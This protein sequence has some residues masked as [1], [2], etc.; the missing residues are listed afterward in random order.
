MT[1]LIGPRP[2]Q[3]PT[4]GGKS[5]RLGGCRAGSKSGREPNSAG[6]TG[7]HL[8]GAGWTACVRASDVLRDVATRG[9][10]QAAVGLRRSRTLEARLATIQNVL[11]W[12]R[13]RWSDDL[14]VRCHIEAGYPLGPKLGL[15]LPELLRRERVF[16]VMDRGQCDAPCSSPSRS[17]RVLRLGWPRSARWL[18]R[19]SR[20][21]SPCSKS[22]RCRRPCPHTRAGRWSL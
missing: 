7:R 10:H 12:R 9:P 17:C 4:S 5:P 6:G 19:R 13:R 20:C 14:R 2:Y 3:P 21:P 8:G 15:E 22:R 16:R 1:E 11:G 18:S